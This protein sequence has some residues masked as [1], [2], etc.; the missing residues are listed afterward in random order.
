[1]LNQ[2]VIGCEDRSKSNRSTRTL[3]WK[4]W[5]CPSFGWHFL[6][7][8]IARNI[9]TRDESCQLFIAGPRLETLCTF[10]SLKMLRS[11]IGAFRT[12][13]VDVWRWHFRPGN[14]RQWAAPKSLLRAVSCRQILYFLS[15]RIN[16]AEDAQHLLSSRPCPLPLADNH[17]VGRRK[18]P[19]F[20][21]TTPRARR[22]PN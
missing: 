7:V 12:L 20:S 2:Q 3:R 22:V 21:R 9:R 17:A 1:M 18:F 11:L 15:R 14:R 19:D 6:P 5:H 4:L 8:K 10:G 16:M 13:R